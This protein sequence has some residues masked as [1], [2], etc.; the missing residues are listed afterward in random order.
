MFVDELGWGKMGTDYSRWFIS[1]G[2]VGQMV[3]DEH[4]WPRMGQCG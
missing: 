3:V 4:R 1:T 2:V